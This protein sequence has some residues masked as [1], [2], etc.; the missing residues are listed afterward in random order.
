MAYKVDNPCIP[1]LQHQHDQHI[2]DLVLSSK[3]II[4]AEIRK[5]NYC[6]LV[7]QAVTLSDITRLD[8]CMLDHSKLDGSPSLKSCVTGWVEVNQARPS[9]R[10]WK[11]WRKANCTWSEADGTR[12]EPLGAWL[13]T[14]INQRFQHFAYRSRS[15]I[16]VRRQEGDSVGHPTSSSHPCGPSKELIRKI[17]DLPR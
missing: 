6:R 14:S 12:K 17:Q 8:G 16:R 11:L 5:L 10:E 13:E 1:Q 9:P 15:R 3:L 7:F 2:A 4:N